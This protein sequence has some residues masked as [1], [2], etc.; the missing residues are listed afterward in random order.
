MIIVE[1]KSLP[2]QRVAL[3]S[4]FVPGMGN[5]NIG[6]V[7][8]PM[9]AT[10]AQRLEAAGIGFGSAVAVYEARGDAGVQVDAAFQVE[11]DVTAGEGFDVVE[12]PAVDLTATTVHRGSMATIGETWEALM[13]WVV[14]HG[15]E[16]AGVCREFYLVSETESQDEWVTELQ[17][18][19]MRE[20]A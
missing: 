9:Y 3:I 18:P 6:P 15:Y 11:S 20:A 10:L 14:E 16:P 13:A 7:I 17:Q 8:G 4:D 12:L 5:E 2:S 19:I 1:T